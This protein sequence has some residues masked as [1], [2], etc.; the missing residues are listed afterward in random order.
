LAEYDIIKRD[1]TDQIQ[2]L[3]ENY[4]ITAKTAKGE[5]EKMWIG[6]RGLQR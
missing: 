3:S 4:L 1:V 5:E 6:T 2:K